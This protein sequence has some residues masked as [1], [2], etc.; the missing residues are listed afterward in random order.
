MHSEGFDSFFKFYFFGNHILF[1]P[2]GDISHSVVNAEVNNCE[3][4]NARTSQLLTIDR[5]A[6]YNLAGKLLKVTLVSAKN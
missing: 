6:I 2:V 3:N 1:Y 4:E 5:T